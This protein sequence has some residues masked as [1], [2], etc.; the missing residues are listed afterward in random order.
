MS[1]KTWIMYLSLLLLSALFAILVDVFTVVRRTGYSGNGNPGWLLL[2]PG[3]FTLIILMLFTFVIAVR[4]FDILQDYIAKLSYHSLVPILSVCTLFLSL[5]LELRKIKLTLASL[6]HNGDE[7]S[8]IHVLGPVNIYTNSL[9]YNMY[10][11][12]FCFSL[13]T[14]G[15]WWV[16]Q[17]RKSM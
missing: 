8:L 9:F 12:L 4:Y 6:R 10:I 11:L 15:G 13:A 14:L 2:Y 3:W 5:F 7:E 16:V 1:A 17:Q